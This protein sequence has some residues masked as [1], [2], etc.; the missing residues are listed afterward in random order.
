MNCRKLSTGNQVEG[1]K[2]FFVTYHRTNLK[3]RQT[4]KM[5]VREYFPGSLAGLCRNIVGI[6]S[7]TITGRKSWTDISA[8]DPEIWPNEQLF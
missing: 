4:S 3:L 8:T 1:R 6:R 7:A 5:Y 2:S